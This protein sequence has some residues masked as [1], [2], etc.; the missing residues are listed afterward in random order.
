MNKSIILL[1]FAVFC[2][3]NNARSQ[4]VNLTVNS[5]DSALR[6]KNKLN[7]K[8]DTLPTFDSQYKT[9]KKYLGIKVRIDRGTMFQETI[10]FNKQLLNHWEKR[11]S[12]NKHA[13]TLADFYFLDN[14]IVKYINTKITVSKGKQEEQRTTYYV[15]SGSFIKINYVNRNELP[16]QKLAHIL[17]SLNKRQSILLNDLKK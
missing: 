17:L 15:S 8:L 7:G 9:Y 13:Y 11:Q 16:S 12:S 5:I 2:F 3:A 6:S 14:M 4:L 1:A 10:L